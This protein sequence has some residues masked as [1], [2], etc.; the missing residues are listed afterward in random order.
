MPAVLPMAA[1]TL[2]PTKMTGTQGSCVSFADP[3]WLRNDLANCKVNVI[4]TS[5]VEPKRGQDF[6]FCRE[7]EAAAVAARQGIRSYPD[8]PGSYRV[9]AAALGQ[10]GRTAEAKEALEQAIAIAPEHVEADIRGRLPGVRPEDH[11]HVL[12]G[13]RKAGWED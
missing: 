2:L 10:L 4:G 13:L 12:E 1:L 11:A 9:L 7:Y 6:Y 3:R 5:D 8:R